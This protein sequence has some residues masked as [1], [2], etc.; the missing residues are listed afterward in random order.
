MGKD[1]EEKKKNSQNDEIEQFGQVFL[2]DNSRDHRIYLLSVIGEI[3]GHEVLPSSSKTTKYEHAAFKHHG[4]RCGK[5][6]GNCGDGC[7]LK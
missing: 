7:I 2:E 4:R 3:E 5:R 1:N 6:S